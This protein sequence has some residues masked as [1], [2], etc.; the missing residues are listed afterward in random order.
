MR[1]LL[2]IIPVLAVV[3]ITGVAVSRITYQDLSLIRNASVIGLSIAML[4]M[5][6]RISVA[7]IFA[8]IAM[9]GLGFGYFEFTTLIDEGD[10]ISV[11][12]F[13]IINSFILFGAVFGSSR[14]RPGWV[15][16]PFG[17]IVGGLVGIILVKI[18]QMIPYLNFL[19]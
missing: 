9:F 18:A 14:G 1:V 2:V 19:Q 10:K 11:K 16:G 8:F 4:P 3:A 12:T 5:L 13:Y 15:F 17:G 6:G 7:G